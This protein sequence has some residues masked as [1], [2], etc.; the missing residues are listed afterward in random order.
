[1]LN[2]STDGS[3]EST[4]TDHKL[5]KVAPNKSAGAGPWYA[6]ACDTCGTAV[7]GRDRAGAKRLHDDL[8]ADRPRLEL[9][10][11]RVGKVVR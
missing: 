9:S 8:L 10:A 7:Q 5:R 11:S 4:V 3:E 6:L 2:S 1:V